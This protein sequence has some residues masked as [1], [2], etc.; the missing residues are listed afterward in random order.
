[1]MVAVLPRPTSS[2]MAQGVLAAQRF[3]SQFSASSWCGSSAVPPRTHSGCLVMSG[4]FAAAAYARQAPQKRR[5][6]A[7]LHRPLPQRFLQ[8]ACLIMPLGSVQARL[9][10]P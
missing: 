1:M 8:P 5:N 7:R 4:R 9:P 6:I 3:R 2:A 10:L